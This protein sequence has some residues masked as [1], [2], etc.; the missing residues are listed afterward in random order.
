MN[1]LMTEEKMQGMKGRM[2]G[3]MRIVR[4]LKYFMDY[5]LEGEMKI[6]VDGVM[7]PQPGIMVDFV[8]NAGMKIKK[9][10]IILPAKKGGE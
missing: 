1:G 9:S 10:L 4:S 7:E 3:E 2:S 5:K 6:A 8:M